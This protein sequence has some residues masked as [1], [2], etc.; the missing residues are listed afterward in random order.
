MG[1]MPPLNFTRNKNFEKTLS[2][3]KYNSQSMLP[4]DSLVP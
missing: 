4:D 2:I 3:G 1:A